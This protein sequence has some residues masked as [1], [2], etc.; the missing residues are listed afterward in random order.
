MRGLRTLLAIC[1]ALLMV[2][3]PFSTG[4]AG[5]PN[6]TDPD[7][8]NPADSGHPWD[9]EADETIDPGDSEDGM[10]IT[11]PGIT[12]VR[13]ATAPTFMLN[14]GSRWIAHMAFYL[15]EFARFS[16]VIGKKTGVT[17]PWRA[18]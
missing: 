9:D 17:D 16:E 2:V 8:S 14:G 4:W 12:P 18:Q 3:A 5:D 15:W 6:P 1:L 7:N 10:L 13:T 11:G